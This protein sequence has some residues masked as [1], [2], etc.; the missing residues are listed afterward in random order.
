[1][2]FIKVGTSLLDKQTLSIEKNYRYGTLLNISSI[3]SDY[4]YSIHEDLQTHSLWLGSRDGIGIMNMANEGTFINYKES[5]PEHYLPVREVNTVFRDKNGLMWIGTKGTGVFHT[6][7]HAR[8]FDVLYPR[9]NGKF[10]TD[11]ISTLY[12]A[13]EWSFLDWFRIWSGLPVER[14]EDIFNTLQTSL[15]HFLQPY[16]PRSAARHS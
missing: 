16:F 6:D 10:F 8:S 4:I 15:S 7:T 12:I 9:G 2:V 3:P 14:Q 13:R 5:N 1:M 11:L